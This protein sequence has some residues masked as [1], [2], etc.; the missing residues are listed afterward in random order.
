MVV[1]L[2]HLEV[3]PIRLAFR[4]HMESALAVEALEEA[5]SV[6]GADAEP[7]ILVAVEFVENELVT[8]EEVGGDFGDLGD[9]ED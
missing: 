4:G 9:V 6:V 2:S 7:L 3:G 5:E 8:V 1:G